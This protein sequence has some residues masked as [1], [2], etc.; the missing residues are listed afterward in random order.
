[1]KLTVLGAN[2]PYPAEE[3]ACSGYLLS[4]DSGRTHILFDCGTGVLAALRGVLPIE[5]LTAVVLTHLHYDHM[6]DM[7]PMQYALQFSS[8]ETALPVLAPLAP[9]PVRSLLDAKCFDLALPEDR[10]IGE[11]RLSFIPGVHPVP[12]VCVSVE[13]D[14]A[15]FVY[16]GDTNEN[17]VLEL[18][19]DGADLLLADAGLSSADWTPRAPHLSAAMCGQLG[20]A[21]RV[22]ALVLTHLNPKYD[23]EAL[24]AEARAFYPDAELAVRGAQYFI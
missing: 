7:L 18:F 15:K 2:G 20:S 4:S 19:A 13:G 17:P 16:T 24:A 21:A 3:G 9:V 8:R 14:G 11:F 23:P 10:Q 22:R 6:S 12:C 5:A 1:M